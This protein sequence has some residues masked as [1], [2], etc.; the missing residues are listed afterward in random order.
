LSALPQAT[1][2]AAFEEDRMIWYVDIEHEKALAD[3]SRAPEFEKVRY[4]RARIC[5][6]ASGFPVNQFYTSRSAGNWPD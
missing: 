1:R 6:E 4:Q 2:L 3:A 5:G